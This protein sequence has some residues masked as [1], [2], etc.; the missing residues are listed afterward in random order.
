MY[1]ATRPISASRVQAVAAPDSVFITA[2]VHQLVS[3][4]F[5]V[6]DCSAQRLKGY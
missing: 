3:G 5:V 2:A 1:P 6:E 4:L